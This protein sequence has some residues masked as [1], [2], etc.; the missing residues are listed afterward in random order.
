MLLD[1]RRYRNRTLQ[2]QQAEDYRSSRRAQR[3]KQSRDGARQVATTD[4]EINLTGLERGVEHAFLSACDI[5]PNEVR[6][7]ESGRILASNATGDSL[8]SNVVTVV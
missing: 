2:G 3:W 1:V 7:A 5:P 6:E 4:T 8:P